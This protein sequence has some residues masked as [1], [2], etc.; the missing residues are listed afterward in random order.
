VFVFSVTLTRQS[1]FD[2]ALQLPHCR[3]LKMPMFTDR[4][5]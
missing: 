1:P 2:G 5:L 3:K 4:I